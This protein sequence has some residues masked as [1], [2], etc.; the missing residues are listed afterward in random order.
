MRKYNSSIKTAFLSEAGNQLKNNDYFGFVELDKYACY[1]IADG[2]TDMREA[3]GAKTAISAVI[4]AFQKE[5]GISKRKIKGYL[6]AANKELLQGKS[7][8]K[9]KASITVV[10]SNYE[11]FR[12]AYAGNTR[13]RLYCDGRCILATTDM[14]LSQD[15]VEAGQLM[16]DK[17]A[18]HEERNNLFCYLG[19]EHFKPFIS[20]KIKLCNGDIIPLYTR[21]IW[22]NVDEGELADVF[23]EAGNDPMEE[24]DKVED[25]LL[26]RQ[27]ENLDN[28]TFAAIYIEKIYT[29]PNRKKRIQKA[30]TIS[31]TIVVIAA[32]IG[33]V[34][35]LWNKDRRQKRAEM[36]QYFA[37]MEQYIEDNNFLR[38]KEECSKALEQAKKLKDKET[39]EKYNA[40]F[41]CLEAV[42][43]ADDFYNAG[44]YTSAKDAYVKAGARVRYADNAGLPYIEEKLLRINEYEQVYDFIELG[45]NLFAHD[46]Y[47]QAEEKY[48]EAK[49]KAASIYFDEGKQQALDALEKLYEEWSAVKEEEEKQK[50]EQEKLNEE[51]A[52]KLAAEQAAAAELVRQ[53]EE[54]FS[55]GDYDGA[56]VF[57]LIALEKYA[58]LE[59]TAQIE[60]LNMKIAALKE[61]QEEIAERMKDAKALEDLARQLEE[62]KDYAQ[63]KIHYQY[64]KAI[65]LEIGKDNKADEVQ[66]KI[67]LLD[68][69]EAQ[70]EKEKQKEKEE[71][72]EKEKKEQEEKEKQ[73]QEEKE[74][75][76]QEEKEKQEQ[77][78]KEKQEQ[79][80]ASKK[81][82][83]NEGN[84]KQ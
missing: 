4:D 15:M 27:P 8:E 53:G 2:I 48:M 45:D 83:D 59:D 60:F 54:A 73:E 61:K 35:Y 65:Y 25:L 74:K 16:E 68:A 40:Y 28:Y 80:E 38:A 43:N 58:A 75:K 10:I 21:G 34:V 55:Q 30:V 37:N 9:Q 70:E 46:N 32:V 63:A 42:I 11:K 79:E 81:A 57:Y 67:D 84:D 31:I 3:A 56:N 62:Q 23:A 52:A 71:Q 51:Q 18:R 72:E 44:D 19:K 24:C 49:T 17:I 12:Y 77:E 36:E 6:K 69:K 41:M 22:E 76:E 66:G 50:K 7:Y 47:T 78:E 20:K 29:D 1:V 5:P 33:L 64:A 82:E 13:L 39:Q 14:S 26:S